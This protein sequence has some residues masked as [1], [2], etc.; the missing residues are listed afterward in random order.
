MS[1]IKLWDNG[2]ICSLKICRWSAE[3]KLTDIDYKKLNID[4]TNLP[5]GIT[6]FGKKK[7]IAPHHLKGIMKIENKA[8]SLLARN[9]HPF[10][11]SSCAFVPKTRFEMV[12][13]K[14]G[15]L[16]LQYMTEVESFLS[17]FD[18]FINEVQEKYPKFW[19][20]CLKNLYP[21]NSQILK[22][23]FDF[24]FTFFKMDGINEESKAKMQQQVE[25][26]TTEYVVAMRKKTIEFCDTLRA[27]LT[28]TIKPG[29]EKVKELSG[30][31]LTSFRKYVETFSQMNIFG[32]SQIEK[33]LQD[34]R[35]EFLGSTVNKETF[36]NTNVSNAAILALDEI[37]KSAAINA[38]STS[39]F[40]DSLKRKVII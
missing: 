18:V 23:K 35:K 21:K 14:L 37:T 25:E 2:A 4:A 22:S 10:L 6:D 29:E 27:R 36:D 33:A 38:E 26:F 12:E 40:I 28:G 1:S 8:R 34:F 30:K 19:D 11:V 24:V 13:T 17:K 9:S 5:S 3:A 31:T 39:K 15:E 20:Q 16:R 32:D 7:L